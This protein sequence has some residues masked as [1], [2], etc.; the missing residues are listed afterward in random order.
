[1]LACICSRTRSWSCADSGIGPAA[2]NP[3]TIA[4]PAAAELPA[5]AF[6]GGGS[7]FL[8]VPKG[9]AIAGCVGT[10]MNVAPGCGVFCSSSVTRACNVC[11]FSRS[12]CTWRTRCSV[13]APSPIATIASTSASLLMAL[14]PRLRPLHY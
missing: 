7:F 13:T 9:L 2:V 14:P 8:T 11:A 6:A 10:A 3:P 5:T 1:M 4:L 12:T